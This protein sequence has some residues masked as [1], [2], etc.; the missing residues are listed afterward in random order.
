[1]KQTFE[2]W[3]VGVK[4][5]DFGEEHTYFMGIRK[6][7]SGNKYVALESYPTHIN[8]LKNLF[9]TKDDAI[10]FWKTGM[11]ELCIDR[12]S[13]SIVPVKIKVDIDVMALGLDWNGM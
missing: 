11:W 3:T 9:E 2:G 8:V 6:V 1:M 12:E 13:V 5:V 4:L 7:S 10:D